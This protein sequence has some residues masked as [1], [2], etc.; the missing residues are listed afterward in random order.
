MIN[1]IEGQELDRVLEQC[2]E[3]LCSNGLRAGTLCFDRGRLTAGMSV[4]YRVGALPRRETDGLG[5]IVSSILK[6]GSRFHYMV[7]CPYLVGED[8][9]IYDSQIVPDGLILGNSATCF[10][11]SND[12]ESVGAALGD[13][14][15]E[16]GYV[17]VGETQR[18]V[19]LSP[20][21]YVYFGAA[22]PEEFIQSIFGAS[23]RELR[24][25]WSSDVA[26][27]VGQDEYYKF[28]EGIPY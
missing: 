21:G 24:R 11:V 15:A 1:L 4:G 27:I 7:L 12:A 10:R 13:I 8:L 16:A 3:L 14:I 28:L 19:M 17:W 22:G 25:E 2:R 26:E 9:Q 18:F 23:S 5:Q 6:S 20:P